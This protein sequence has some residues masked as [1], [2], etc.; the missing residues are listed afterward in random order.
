MTRK[1]VSPESFVLSLFRAGEVTIDGSRQRLFFFSL[2]SYCVV[3]HFS[4]FTLV[5]AIA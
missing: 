5:F 2:F 1:C 3:R 4:L